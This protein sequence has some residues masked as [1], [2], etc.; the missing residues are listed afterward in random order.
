MKHYS[1][2]WGPRASG[3]DGKHALVFSPN[4]LGDG[5]S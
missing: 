5:L 1:V 2:F 3:I 4:G